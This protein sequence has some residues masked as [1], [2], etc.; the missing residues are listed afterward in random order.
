VIG[1]RQAV[2]LVRYLIDLCRCSS[3]ASTHLELLVAN[4]NYRP[5][6][7]LVMSD[8]PPTDIFR[9]HSDSWKCLKMMGQ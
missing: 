3:P 5:L 2:N 1:P 7:E 6:D 4:P 8:T 9:N